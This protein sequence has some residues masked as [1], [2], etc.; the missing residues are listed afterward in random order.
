MSKKE[1]EQKLRKVIA[2]GTAIVGGGMGALAGTMLGPAGTVSGAIAGGAIG[3]AA[4]EALKVVG[5]D[6]AN[7]MLGPREQVRVGAVISFAAA[8]IKEKLDQGKILR[9]DGF[10][11]KDQTGRSDAEEVTESVILKAQREPEERKIKYM[12][13][14][15]SNIAFDKEIRSEL[16]HQLINIGG[17][18]TYRQL[19]ILRL[20]VL[21]KSNDFGLRD[22]NYT[23]VEY[24]PRETYQILHEC[25]GLH[26]RGMLSFRDDSVL[27][28]KLIRPSKMRMQGIGADIYN[29]MNLMQIPPNEVGPLVAELSKSNDDLAIDA[30]VE[31]GIHAKKLDNL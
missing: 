12:G 2:S 3:A 4:A 27:S 10:F 21:K 8:D 5:E 18:L 30:G 15:I 26:A 14:L 28:M 13:Y 11:E 19:C 22:S 7:R 23:S 20:A 16:A 1:K 9:D 25:F 29:Q 24:V 31:Q 6:V 17:E